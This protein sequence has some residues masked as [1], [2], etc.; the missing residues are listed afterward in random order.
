MKGLVAPL[1]ALAAGINLAWQVRGLS[2]AFASL[3]WHATRGTVLS[4][5]VDDMPFALGDIGAEDGNH[6][7]H[8]R[9][10][11]QVLGRAYA[12]TRLTYR[13][14]RWI[15]FEEAV[16]YLHGLRRGAEVDVRYDPRRPARAVLVPGPSD[17]NIVRVVLAL[18][19]FGGTVWWWLV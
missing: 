17:E 10:A 12:S 11:Y 14:T 1:L 15:V 16:D 8:V 13:P 18:L 3:R 4:C 7:A 9:Y 5:R 2:L 19:A 6:S